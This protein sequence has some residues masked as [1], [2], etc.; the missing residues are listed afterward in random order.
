M[1]KKKTKKLEFADKMM[2]LDIDEEFKSVSDVDE[3]K[4]STDY[5]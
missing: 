5:I 4:P 1:L 2:I 3:L